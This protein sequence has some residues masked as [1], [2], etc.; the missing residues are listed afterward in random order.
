MKYN[1]HMIRYGA[2]C[3]SF[4]LAASL[5]GCTD[6]KPIDY[7]DDS[8]FPPP[9]V[10]LSSAAS[11]DDVTIGQTVTVS[12][13]ISAPNGLRDMYV[14]IVRQNGD[15]YEEISRNTRAI[16]QLDGF[17]ATHDFLFDITVDQED[18]AA[19]LVLGTDIFTKNGSKYIGI[20]HLSG[21]APKITANPAEIAS[22]EIDGEVSVEIA[23]TSTEG[24]QSVSYVLVQKSPYRE[25]STPVT[26]SVSGD[27][28]K[29]FTATVTVDN[30][31]ADAI[32]VKATDTKGVSRTIYIDIKKITGIPE[33]R[34]Y[35]FD[36]VVMAPEWECYSTA[37][38]KP[39]PSQP[40]LFSI[41]GV[42]TGG[43]LKNV[44]SLSEASVASSGKIDF[45][46]V[47]IW[48]NTNPS[49]AGFLNRLSFRGFAFVST[50]RASGGPVGR[51][52]DTSWLTAVDIT[53]HTQL[54]IIPDATAT[55][56]DLDNLFATATGNWET[57]QALNALDEFVNAYGNGTDYRIL[58]QRLVGSPTSIH[59]QQIFDGTYIAFRTGA[60]K[61]GVIKVVTAAD[62]SDAIDAN[63]KVIDVTSGL[64]IGNTTENKTVAAFYSGPG[65][66]GFD[67]YGAPLLY[68]RSCTLKIIV[69]K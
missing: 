20:G 64:G 36:N 43:N 13:S 39:V 16:G 45:S 2:F 28:E 61:L 17:P 31:D 52:L 22:V 69:Q 68:G 49:D 48:R 38:P 8:A 55:A 10:T 26:V 19:I 7:T 1:K 25:L 34:A 24:L 9:V 54:R 62:D 44:L 3:L 47:N 35:I 33:G 56:M 4:L 37:S 57:F 29:S 51:Q 42:Q 60:N 67:Y 40:S 46:F 11:L 50:S 14:T 53:S 58:S 32:A 15:G 63:G 6:E 12:G 27:A 21:I 5:G 59:I 66:A 18:A 65:L 23:I 41:E 30:E